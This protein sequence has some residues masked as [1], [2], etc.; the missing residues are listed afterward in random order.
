MNV[1]ALFGAWFRTSTVPFTSPAGV[2][3]EI[4]PVVEREV[5]LLSASRPPSA[6]IILPT[7]S[8]A[9]WARAAPDPP[10]TSARRAI[11]SSQRA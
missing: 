9:V 4:W 3:T 2:V 1:R 11:P 10:N 7:T 6:V 8:S 5:S